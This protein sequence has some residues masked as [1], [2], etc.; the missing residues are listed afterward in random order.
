MS[1]IDYFVVVSR[2]ECAI[3]GKYTWRATLGESSD[4][5][6]IKFAGHWGRTEWLYMSN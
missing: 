6:S 1:G 3:R 5:G 4:G 2:G